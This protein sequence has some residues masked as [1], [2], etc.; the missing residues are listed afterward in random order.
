MPSSLLPSYVDDVLEFTNLAGFPATGETSKIYVALDTNKAYRWSG[1]TYI[2]ISASPGTTDSLS[3][4]SVSLYFTEARA[5]NAIS[6]SGSLSYDAATGVMSYTTPLQSGSTNLGYTPSTRLLT[7]DTGDDVTLP[8]V[9]TA[10]AGL[11][12]PTS[13]APLTPTTGTVLLDMALLNGQCRT[14]G[15]LTGDL[16]FTASN[17]V[18]S[19]E[20]RLRLICGDTT[21]ALTFPSDWKFLSIKPSSITASKVAVL[22]LTAFGS[23]NAEV[24]VAYVEQV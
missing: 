6:A 10:D 15:P 23:T 2:E 3:E 18:T 8:L 4:G 22:S 7:S 14:I 16:T 24:I 5:R 13:Y 21:R 11:Q 17:L 9:T 1:S 12:L 20:L 19:R